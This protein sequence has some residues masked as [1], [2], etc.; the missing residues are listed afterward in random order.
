[1]GKMIKTMVVCIGGFAA[2]YIT[3]YLAG[4][5]IAQVVEGI[6]EEPEEEKTEEEFDWLD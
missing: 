2:V 4:A 6:L 3:G 1:M 5:G